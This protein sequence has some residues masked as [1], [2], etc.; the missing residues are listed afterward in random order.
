[1]QSYP[2]P[3]GSHLASLQLRLYLLVFPH[4]LSMRWIQ[5][6]NYRWNLWTLLPRDDYQAWHRAIEIAGD[7]EVIRKWEATG[8]NR[9]KELNLDLNLNQVLFWTP[10]S[11][12][13]PRSG[14]KRN[15]A[16]S[17]QYL[18]QSKESRKTMM[19]RRS[20]NAPPNFEWVLF[21]PT[22]LPT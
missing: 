13:G 5:R 9:I 17:P 4:Y 7:P 6:L 15:N 2:W 19:T 22:S 20:I 10:S 8:R 18:E 14:Q 1:M 21:A 11:P 3:T 12:I 16:L